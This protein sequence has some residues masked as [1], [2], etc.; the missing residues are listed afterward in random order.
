MRKAF[1]ILCLLALLASV[2]YMWHTGHTFS[3]TSLAQGNVSAQ[4][5]S[6]SDNTAST[7]ITGKPTISASFINLVLAYY[8]SPAEGLGTAIYNLGVQYSINPVYALAFFMHESSFGNAGVARATLS[9]GNIRCSAGYVCID[10]YRAYS[11]WASGFQDWY[12][13]IRV[14]YVN[15]WHLTTI[16]AIIPTYAPA[17]DHNNVAAYITAI[18]RAV[19]SWQRG[20][21]AA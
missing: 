5:V 4:I 16:Q 13:L 14:V 10:G 1:A 19:S 20:D 21:V 12:H 6:Q 11:N 18:E 8:H 15:Q 2:L 3:L 9:L 7:G 17:G